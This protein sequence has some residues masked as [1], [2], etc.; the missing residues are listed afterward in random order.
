MREQSEPQLFERRVK[1]ETT[2]LPLSLEVLR[3]EVTTLF[4]LV[5]IAILTTNDSNVMTVNTKI[6]I[7]VFLKLVLIPKQECL[8]VEG[9]PPACQ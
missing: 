3:N 5:S 7:T 4:S 9:P 1:C 8:S 6:V 2:I